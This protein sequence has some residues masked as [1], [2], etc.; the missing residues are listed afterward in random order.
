MARG[1]ERVRGKPPRIMR[2]GKTR[3]DHESGAWANHLEN[4][5]LRRLNGS[6]RGAGRLFAV[7]LAVLA[8]FVLSMPSQSGS[9][10]VAQR[11]HRL[12]VA[13]AI[14]LASP[15]PP[16][17]PARRPPT[18]RR[19]SKGPYVRRLQSRLVAL[20]YLPRGSVNGVFGDE[21]WHAVVAFQGWERL[22]RDGIAG[23]K[24]NAALVRARPPRAWGGLRRGLEID[25]A[26]QVML[27]VSHRSV[28]LAVHICS[29]KAGYSTPTGQFSVYRRERLSWSVRYGAWM[30]YA[31]YFYG[32]QAIHGFGYV[33]AEPVSHGCVRMPMVDAPTVW[34]FA[35]LGTPVW[36]R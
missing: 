7:A 4:K 23:P 27:L 19:G 9:R 30:P 26:R 28:V 36:I 12:V 3:R 15:P 25:L 10:R 34:S 2:V 16:L 11:A 5:R 22:H 24:T 1:T 6:G 20:R 32:G 33:P 29:G 17:D 8:L 35:P 14:R 13:G 21:T 18:L 31:L